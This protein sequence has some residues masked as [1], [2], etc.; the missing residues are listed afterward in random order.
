M[1]IHHGQTIELVIR[2]EGYSISEL[3]RLAKVNRRSVY[4]WFNQQYLKTELIYQ[5]GVYIKHDFSIEFPHLFKTEDFSQMSPQVGLKP[6]RDSVPDQQNSE[7]WKDKYL[8]ILEK[9]NLLL[10]KIAERYTAELES[11]IDKGL[12][13]T[14][15]KSGS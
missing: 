7:Y 8:D 6:T 5:I 2:R 14:N 4:Y 1:D 9:Y 11:E 15:L 3:A 13:G 12:P 10:T